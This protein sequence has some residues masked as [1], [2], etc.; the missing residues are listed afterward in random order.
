MCKRGR[1]DNVFSSFCDFLVKLCLHRGA[2][3]EEFST[4]SQSR[5]PRSSVYYLLKNSLKRIT[6]F[7]TDVQTW[8]LCFIC[9]INENFT[10]VSNLLSST[11]IS[12]SKFLLHQK[13]ERDHKS[14]SKGRLKAGNFT[15]NHKKT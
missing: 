1:T 8:L 12:K 2:S 15:K 14:N 4:R 11:L 3:L 9:V 5:I 13:I 6:R 7:A 10:I